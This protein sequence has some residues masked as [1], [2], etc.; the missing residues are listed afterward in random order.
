[1]IQHDAGELSIPVT[2]ILDDHFFVH[3]KCR[4][5]V[6]RCNFFHSFCHAE[7]GCITEPMES[8]KTVVHKE[9]P[10]VFVPIHDWGVLCRSV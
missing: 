9:I 7:H 10:H 3:K 4:Q 1:M 2:V 6:I 5:S 8:P